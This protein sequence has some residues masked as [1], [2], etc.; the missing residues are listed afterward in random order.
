MSKCR[1]AVSGKQNGLG[2]TTRTIAKRSPKK[3]DEI[4]NAEN[5]ISDGTQLT[6]PM[7]RSPSISS[8]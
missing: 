1:K 6:K 8:E 3:D 7:P 5:E 4:Q 2:G